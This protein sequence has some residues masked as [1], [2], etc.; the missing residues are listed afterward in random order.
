MEVRNAMNKNGATRGAALNAMGRLWVRAGKKVRV[1]FRARP[2]DMRRL[3]AGFPGPWDHAV[4][5][6]H[7]G[8]RARGMH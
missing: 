6:V 4:G 8:L 2:Q 5:R 1:W 3:E 7:A